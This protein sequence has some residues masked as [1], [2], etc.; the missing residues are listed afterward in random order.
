MYCQACILSRHK[1]LSYHRI[2]QW[3]GSFFDRVTLKE[4]GLKI[5]LGHPA[6]DECRSPKQVFNDDFTVIHSNGI[7]SVS[8]QYCDCQQSLRPTV[9]LLRSKL[10]PSTT[11]EP[12]TAATFDVLETFQML[13]FTSKITAYDYYNSLH[14]RTDNTG[15]SQPP[16]RYHVFLRVV[17]E[18]RHLR[19]LKRMG[20]GHSETGVVGTK[21]GECAVLCPAC[22]LPGINLPD[23]WRSWPESEQ[24]LYSQFIAI[25][26]NFRLKRFN[27]SNNQ[28]DPGLN[29]GYAY[30][31]EETR[32]K[33]YLATYDKKIHEE[34]ST[35]N[36]HDAIKLA[37]QR[38]G[39]GTAAN[40]SGTAECGRHDMKRPNG[41][42]D[43]QKGERY[44]N[45]DYFFLTSLNFNTPARLVVSYDITC[46]W[47]RNLLKRVQSYPTNPLS[48]DEIDLMFLVP[49]FHLPAH[50]EKCQTNYSFNL[51]PGVGR[52]D[53]EAPERGWS[54]INA[55]ATS[56]KEMGP[57]SRHD[58]LDDLFGARN[59]L[60]ITNIS[61][62]F[63][64]KI[65]EALAG[66]KEHVAAF[67]E[68]DE[69][70]SVD[71]AESDC[72]VRSKVP[73][74]EWTQWCQ[75]WEKNRDPH[76][77]PF[78][79]TQIKISDKEV[80]LRLAQK[81]AES[82]TR[83][84]QRIIHNEMSPSVLIYQGLEIEDL[85]RK[86]ALDSAALGS[87]STDLQ[88]AKIIE[89]SNY[90]RRK[91]EAWIAVEHMYVPALAI[92]RSRANVE[93]G[94]SLAAQDIKLY[95]PSELNASTPAQWRGHPS[96]VRLPLTISCDM[97]LVE[98]EWE[99]RYAMADVTL[100]ALRSHLIIRS[101]LYKSKDLHSRGQY[102]NTRSN[103]LIHTVEARIKASMLKYR[104]IREAMLFL[105]K[106]RSGNSDWESIY[107]ALHD[108]DVRGLTSIDDE[109][110][111]GHKRLSWIWKVYGT[112]ETGL[113][114][115]T[116]DAL[117]IEWCRA[118]ARAHRWQ[119]ECLLLN[120][121][122]RRVLQYFT[123]CKE[124]WTKL[125]ENP[126]MIR[127]Q[128]PR[129]VPPIPNVKILD[130]KRAYA[131]RQASIQERIVDNC[132]YQWRGLSEQLLSM[133]GRD[134]MIMVEHSNSV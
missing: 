39:A 38:G 22:P 130:G 42:G 134:P 106:R 101:R 10:F 76:N 61:S 5:Q 34:K 79:V 132:K 109:G 131:L 123:T 36:N 92:V 50:V 25:D 37:Q 51:V 55:V 119:E 60:K 3:N 107:K 41:I 11:I 98:A 13:S 113:D 53:G 8:L 68:F 91:I 1:F 54:D 31:V 116:Q 27:V 102:Q 18:W 12:R 14:A 23:D 6:G 111:E 69:A 44:V 20:R 108:D 127:E 58:T 80:R 56:M 17:R 84:Q 47:S 48:N 85:Q 43:L 89:R 93:G 66:R 4:L 52:T 117:R 73:I 104:Y 126:P 114:G 95:L 65:T 103:D 24:W 75:E 124:W 57:G 15:T 28:R 67:L 94:G 59:W 99:L 16:D 77:N 90:L 78:E 128:T 64:R 21:E 29:H 87:H 32:F 74:E 70:L 97:D 46:Q 125:A 35:C 122:M 9:Q 118:R 115:G 19:L 33:Q 88:R 72:D 63:V 120:E 110:A 45:M 86:L 133:D 121:E 40:G 71:M 105:S 82:I 26:A 96:S 49:K 100:N 81:D 83:G 62:T 112:G 2:A 7:H 129:S 30:V